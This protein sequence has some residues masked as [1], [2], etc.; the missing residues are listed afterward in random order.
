M[1]NKKFPENPYIGRIYYDGKKTY[2][3]ITNL[4]YNQIPGTKPQSCWI[5]IT[6]ELK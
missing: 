1:N 5:D 4:F 3:Y 2:E 6:L